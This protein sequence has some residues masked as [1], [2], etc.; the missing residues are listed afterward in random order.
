MLSQAFARRLLGEKSEGSGF[1]SIVNITSVNATILGLNRA[2]YCVSKAALAMTTALF[3]ARLAEA[4]IGVYEVRPG[5]TLT[6][7]VRPSMERYD[8]LIA[9]GLVPMKRWGKPEDVAEVVAHLASGGMAFTTGDAIHV[10]GGLHMY[11]V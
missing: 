9:D 8:A 5:I 6:E 3:A 2:D 11:R 7:M 1:R 4:G 10:D